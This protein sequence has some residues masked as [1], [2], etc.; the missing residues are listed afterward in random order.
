MNTAIELVTI[1]TSYS[2]SKEGV[3]SAIISSDLLD[4]LFS[5]DDSLSATAKIRQM[6]S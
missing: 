4:D 1:A 5:G 6:R 2:V 3:R